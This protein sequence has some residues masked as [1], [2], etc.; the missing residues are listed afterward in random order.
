MSECFRKQM[1]RGATYVPDN[2]IKHKHN[3]CIK[4]L[5]IITNVNKHAS[6]GYYN[7]KEYFYVLKCNQCDSFIP[8]SVKG[9]YGHWI[10]GDEKIDNSLPVITANTMQKNMIYNNSQLIDVT[11]IKK[12]F[13]LFNKYKLWDWNR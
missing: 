13:L 4:H 1:L 8:D 11:V 10:F 12:K 7:S 9:N 3:Y 6:S 2:I 5:L